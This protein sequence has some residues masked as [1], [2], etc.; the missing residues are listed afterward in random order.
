VGLSVQQLEELMRQRLADGYVLEPQLSISVEA[1]RNRHVYVL[2]AVHNPGIYPL[3][4][5]ATLLELLSQ[6]GGPIRTSHAGY[7]QVVRPVAQHNGARPGTTRNLY[8]PTA[9]V[10]DVDKL[11]A[12]QVTPPIRLE[13]GYLAQ[14]WQPCRGCQTG[15]HR[16]RG[17][18]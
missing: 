14:W 3:R 6:A 4:H 12:G 15:E 1:Y 7:V 10:I 17:L 8:S 13:S 18:C 2:G 9:L 16:G 5:E 11:L